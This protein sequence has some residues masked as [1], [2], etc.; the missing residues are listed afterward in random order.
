MK[1]ELAAQLLKNGIFFITYLPFTGNFKYY[2][3]FSLL[4]RGINQT[5]I[6]LKHAS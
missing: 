6:L 3:F 1:G 2:W 4:L 5:I